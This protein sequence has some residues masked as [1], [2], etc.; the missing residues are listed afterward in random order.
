M[1]RYVLLIAC[2]TVCSLSFSAFAQAPVV[3]DSENYA[4]LEE[5]QVGNEQPVARYDYEVGNDREE[6]PA[7]AHDDG[8]LNTSNNASLLD[9]VQGLQQE[10]QELRGQ[11]EIQA[12]DLKLL[13]EQ[14]LSFYKDLD[15]R[16]RDGS[17]KGVTT[18]PT[19]NVSIDTQPP[20]S[21]TTH[22]PSSVAPIAAPAVVAFTNTGPTNP[23][24]EQIS[25]MAAYDFVKNK[26]FDRALTAL[27]GFII[28]YP[29]GGYTANA[30]YW[31]GE[32][33]MVKGN[34]DQAINHFNVVL[35][36]YPS[37][38]KRA[39]SLLKV[40]YALAALGKTAQARERL[41]DVIKKYPDTNTAQL[42]TAK[43][44]TLRNQ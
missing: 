40:G 43:L 33:Y 17:V 39:A 32:L 1:I 34:H 14:Q 3:D 27:Q 22:T 6:Q 20:P 44:N 28:K 24:D 41:L 15:A 25:Y 42:A 8:Q 36:D 19:A 11:L 37:S 10:V 21:V 4:L 18:K 31:I 23:A 5:Q 30:E 29:H 38:S 7:L 13:Q 16:L 2:F 12:H 35:N 9:K 26:Q